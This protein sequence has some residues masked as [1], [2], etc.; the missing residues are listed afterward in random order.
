M[1]CS[2]VD[3]FWRRA[4]RPRPVLGAT[5]LGV[6]GLLAAMPAT[7]QTDSLARI[8]PALVR[9]DRHAPA[10]KL[11][12]HLDRPSYVS[13][14]TMWFKLYAVDG[15]RH[16]P[17]AASS[18]AY[19]E[20]LNEEKRPVLQAK[21]ALRQATG[22]GS[23]V[24]PPALPS[25]RYTV[26]AYTSWMKNF[27]P[28]L[29]FHSP[30]TIVNT[31]TPL[32]VPAKSAALSYDPQFFPEGGNL[33]QGV[34]SKV[35]F[36]ITD[37]QGRSVAAEGTVLDQ[38][39]Q[40]VA[41]FRTLQ[42]GLGSFLF[43][44]TQEG[45]PYSAV[46]RVAGQPP[47][48]SALPPVRASG[49]GLR[50]EDE[51]AQQLRLVVEVKGAVPANENLFLLA[52]T[53]QQPVVAAAGQLSQGQALFLVDKQQLAAGITHFTLFNSQ[54]QPVGERL[55]F[56]APTATLPLSARTDKTQYAPRQK[57]T[58]QLAATA[59]SAAE[60]S[61]A[62][63]QL[64]S[65]SAAGGADISS[66]LWLSSDVKGT[67]EHPE[68]YLAPGREAAA[69]NLMLTQGWSRFRWA[70]VLA[71]QPR[72][73]PYLPELN[74]HVVRGRV[75]NSA[76][77]APAEGIVAY[78]TAPSRAIQLYNSVSRPDGSVQ[79]ETTQFYGTRQLVAQP[80]TAQD[81]LYRVELL[82]PFSE[83][84]AAGRPTT[85]TLAEQLA[86][87]LQRRHVQAEVQ[88]H[89]LGKQAVRYLAPPADS[90]A[91]YGKP[92]EQYLLDAYTRFKVME[93]VMRE[94]VPGVLVRIRK[95]GFHFLVPNDNSRGVEENPLV[96]LDGLPVFNTNRIMAFD[97]LKVQKLDVV[98]RRYFVGKQVYNGIVSYTTYKGD[99]AG[100]PLDAHAL[101]QEYEGLQGQREFYAP[102]YDTPQQQ[103]SRLP[104]FRNLLYWNP[105]VQTTTS[106]ELPFFT[107]DQVGRYRVVVQGLTKDGLPGTAS[108][109]FEVKPSL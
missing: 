55:Y 72:P 99:L 46:I 85:F 88:Q 105:S 59:A 19:V 93:E 20:V 97:P 79:F 13:G 29:Y 31:R 15:R 28:E 21:I 41:T 68:Y 104:D 53:R 73:L 86:A 38:A 1:T 70:E 26:R 49:Y 11:F 102:R 18:V 95:D 43:T 77:G 14:E 65:L 48:T 51:D 98:T 62:V 96:L 67:V 45:G 40:S 35:G 5:V 4:A 82:N 91:F 64:D 6:L 100:F 22:H 75:L 94:Y 17:L 27:G 108:F 71:P 34:R 23:L 36:K 9:Y 56:R 80:N 50:L 66:Y 12:L 47:I 103:Q 109:T 81:S 69:D 78:L 106:T 92:S 24:L 83:Q 10:E 2:S 44:P 60:L 87:S 107:S 52:H 90:T 74:G 63:Y 7:A 37:S 33:V 57:V 54:R 101:L 39:G 84:Y 42:F 76:T 16:Q 8:G 61:V 30:V 58:L 25:G 32:S 3:F 89:Y